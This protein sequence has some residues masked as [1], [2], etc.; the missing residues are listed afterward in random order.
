MKSSIIAFVFTVALGLG[1]I[2]ATGYMQRLDNLGREVAALER[3][4]EHRQAMLDDMTRVV[5]AQRRQ[6]LEVE[7]LF[8]ASQ[9]LEFFAHDLA[10]S[11]AAVNITRR[12]P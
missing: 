10:A 8:S 9:L 3:Q 4:I 11:G 5:E 1:V 7:T 2:L 6:A 12:Q